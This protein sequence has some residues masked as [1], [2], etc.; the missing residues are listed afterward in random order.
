MAPVVVSRATM[1][2]TVVRSA[3]LRSL[4]TTLCHCSSPRTA[5]AAL[6]GK[7]D[8]AWPG[9][10]H[11]L[12]GSV[13][14]P[15]FG[16]RPLHRM[17]RP[18]CS[19]TDA[20]SS[21]EATT[22]TQDSVPRSPAASMTGA[23]IRE[24]FLR[25]FEDRG[26]KRLPSSSLVPEDPTVL[27]TI[28]GMLQFKPI[29]L[30]QAARS[31]PCATTTQKCIRT[32]DIENVGVTARHH[33][34]FE[35]LGNFSFG[36]YFKSEAI[37][38]GW[39]LA[40]REFGLPAERVFVSVFEE[41]DEAFAI[42]R[43]EVGV[44]EAQI[45]RMGA[46][47]NFWA[48]G[49]TGPCGPCSELYYDFHPERGLDGIDLDDD[50]RFIEFYNMVFMELNR[51]PD[52]S[53]APLTNKNIDTGMGLERMAQILQ[54]KPNNYETDLI[55]PV[56]EAAAKL[57]GLEYAAASEA[58]KTSLKVIGD[59][60]RAVTYL[61]SDGVLPSNVGRGYVVRRLL[62]RVVMKGRILGIDET[63]TPALAEV[64]A[65]LSGPCDPAV[66][67]N[68][69]RIFEEMGRE[70][71]RFTQTLERGQRN[72]DELLEAATKKDGSGSLSGPDAFMLYDTFG[73]PLEITQ[74]VAEAA[75][76]AVDTEG[77]AQEMEAQRKRAQDA[78]QEVD[79][80]ARLALGE[81]AEKVGE[82]EFV[83]YER[84]EGSG[85][86]LGLLTGGVSVPSASADPVDPVAVEVLLDSTPFYAESGGQ[87]GDMGRL[88]VMGSGGG[89]VEV[90][91]V[92]KGG[93]GGL[94]VHSGVLVEGS[95][96]VGDEAEARVD[97]EFRGRVKGHH[98]ATH[99][100]QA[101]L[102]KVLGG[103]TS[104]QGS[105]VDSQRL[106]FDFNLHRGMEPPELAEVERLVNAWVQEARPLE[107][108]VMAIAD[109]KEAGAT[110]MFGEKYG[111]EVRV[112]DVPGRSMELCG[113]THVSN[114]SEIGGFKI[115]SESGIASGVR[116]I[117]AVVGAAQVEY[118]DDVDG[119]VR[120][121]AARFK[122]KPEGVV[123]RVRALQDD[124]KASAAEIAALKGQIALAKSAA[125]VSEAVEVGGG[126]MLVQSME[127]VAA[128][129]LQSAATDLQA[130]L[131][132]KG[133]VVL[134]SPSPSGD[135]KVS[136]VAAFGPEAVKGG[137]QAGKFIG[138]LAKICGGGGGGR[139][140]LAQA[141]GKDA[142][143]IPEALE[144]ARE[145]LS[146]QLA[147]L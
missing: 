125:L 104:Q 24:K 77:F 17:M 80:T 33:T 76:V 92:T 68:R 3:T 113:G 120:E 71:E 2:V 23:E 132:P 108:S 129:D 4:R 74:E 48:S 39:E 54:G 53:T 119:I 85:R 116:R 70:E 13:V 43:D 134:V 25:Y 127:G 139:P 112:V 44:P 141:G 98:T 26:H 61:I 145:Q 107:V 124:L 62:R 49:A 69:E 27:L 94:F 21:S 14:A 130:K 97:E 109:A 72:L 121:L 50:S 111:D 38:M 8:G 122:V 147:G 10:Q 142:S 40:T 101:A 123:G 102:K 55:F 46:E 106:R 114:T 88:R 135:G 83:G 12:K 16:S 96:S 28:A 6:S 30:G 126:K 63:F 79:L 51:A 86:V 136:M 60:V 37:A 58:E 7:P 56:L 65:S 29:F 41:D 34:F 31:V 105:L 100:L 82:T 143:K 110:A 93:G 115:V 128:A 87:V 47:D 18:I 19:A 15:S 36:D 75:G 118:L 90:R 67:K 45:V 57:A 73:F 91:D 81:L 32:N 9:S 95:V 22:T 84:L 1:S 133:A 117:E 144:A 11:T 146:E 131:G 89:V 59:H 5:A 52:G 140:N 66:Q 20:S 137:M 99:L 64:V 42:W 103:N 35:M 78:R 138:G